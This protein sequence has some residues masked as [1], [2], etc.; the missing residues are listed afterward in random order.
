MIR[1]LWS[2]LACQGFVLIGALGFA[3]PVSAAQFPPA[4][5]EELDA[6]DVREA[7]EAAGL[8]S[9]R[10]VTIPEPENLY[11]FLRQGPL[12]KRAVI[13]LGKAFFWDM[14]VGSDGQAC[15]TCHFSAGADPRAKNQLSPG[16]KNVNP[17]LQ[18]VFDPTASGAA[19]GPNYE[20]SADDFPFHQLL[21]PE[22]EDFDERVVT[23]DSDDVV[24]SQGVSGANFVGLSGTAKDLGT[25]IVDSVFNVAGVNTRR[26]E[27][28]NTPTM[29]NAVFNFANFWDG[30]AH[31]EFN[32]VS[33]LG[34]LDAAAQVYVRVGDNLVAKSVSL[35]NSS[36]ASQAV[37]P[38][39]S[40]LEM[41]FFDRS[42]P[43]V[44]RKLLQLRPLKL[45]RVHPMDSALGYLS[46]AHIAN[47]QA[48]G[49]RGLSISYEDLI[50]IAFRPQYWSSSQTVDGFTQM[51]AN[52]SLFF[53]LAI[54]MYEST[55][56]SDRTPFDR[57]MEGH[58]NAL[59]DEQLRGLLTFIRRPSS[60]GAVFTEAIGI[61]NCVSCHG[62]AEFTDAAFSSLQE[63]DELELIEVEETPELVDGLMEVGADTAFLDNGFSNIGVRPTSED[64]GRGSM[65]LGQPLA[66]IRQA[67][68]GLPFAPEVPDC[69]GLD[70]PDCPNAS[71]VQV[72]GAFKIP[73]LRNAELTGPY[74]HN[75]GQATLEQV[76]EF[77]DRRGDFGDVN[78][79]DIDR[80]MAFI[81]IGDDDEDPLIEFLVALTDPR[82]RNESGVFDHPELFVPNGHLG[83]NVLLSCVEGGVAC[84]DIL[85]I[86]AIG[87]FGRAFGGLDPLEPFLGI[88]ALEEE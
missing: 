56:V 13:A 72:D 14:Q 8:Q 47:G 38:P 57:F 49:L 19:G 48:A 54:Q 79:A 45:Q 87:R 21:D 70:E 86:P 32:G 55:L 66:F 37:G 52:F 7:A 11:S 4:G 68:L 9:L 2:S 53:G 46:R 43:E 67:L 76:V 3:L 83:D 28:R 23:F 81:A 62:G 41:S 84:D 6:D 40:N 30:R 50:K 44:G 33:P 51:E 63:D 12:A 18:D 27:P 88:P 59:E 60:T 5:E 61:G 65:E 82:V 74:F 20:L 58:D 22:E 26:V 24:S 17:L 64:L 80:N 39:L 34:P 15:A 73:G 16:L 35:P 75:G 77:Y 71:R 31:N 85:A 42:F 25:P 78:L 69:G 29:I 36:L 1:Y 10:N